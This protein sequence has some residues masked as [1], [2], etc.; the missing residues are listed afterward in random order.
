MA[1]WGASTLKKDS[2]CESPEVGKGLQK[3]RK[4]EEDSVDGAQ[5]QEG[6][7]GNAV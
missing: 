7:L 5:Q 3:L 4:S 2:T 6:R 1:N